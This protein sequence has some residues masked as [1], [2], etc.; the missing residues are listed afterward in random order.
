[1]K[2]NTVIKDLSSFIA[3]SPTPFH[4]VAEGKRRL[5]ANGFKP[6]KPGE[7]AGYGDKLYYAPFDVSLFAFSIGA[8][9]RSAK[10]GLKL[11]LA[12]AHIDSPCIHIKP[13]PEMKTKDYIRLNADVYG[14]PIINT[15]LDRPLSIAGQVAIAGPDGPVL[16]LFDAKDPVVS[17][18]NLAIHMNREVN[19][20]V[21]LNRQNDILPLLGLSGSEKDGEAFTGF[22]A[23]KLHVKPEEILDLDLYVYNTE[24]P[25][26]SGLNGEFFSC[27][28]LDDL[29]SAHAL[30]CALC[31]EPAPA[32]INIAAFFN[33]EE[34]GSLSANGADSRVLPMLLESLYEALGRS[35]SALNG[36]ILGGTLLSLDVAHAYHPN[37]TGKY[38]PT[39]YALMGDG[40]VFK[41]NSNQKYINDLG[42]LAELEVLCKNHDIPYKRFVNRSDVA[43]GGTIGNMLASWLPMK[44]LDLGVPILAMH[45]A[46]E[47]MGT[48]D[49]KA[50]ID[51]LT[52][53]FGK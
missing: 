36:D 1:M 37:M 39:N 4:A 43:G 17:I 26:F 2:K 35:K 49:Q 6:W 15:W 18:P 9:P 28:R 21:E 25:N 16:K 47:T 11:K 31:E 12:G 51:L 10:A 14:G 32:S 46:R 52:A 29:T 8:K 50:L 41:L 27:P 42:V 38:D 33:N 5:E 20:G 34:V 30:L 19:K 40:V 48:N 53:F 23:K 24:E 13:N 22:L 45:S 44:G 7:K 3:A